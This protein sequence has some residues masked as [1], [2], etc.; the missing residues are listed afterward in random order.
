MFKKDDKVYSLLH[1]EGTII[2]TGKYF[3][4]VMF[5]ND[6]AES[7]IYSSKGYFESFDGAPILFHGK[8]EIIAPPEPQR[9]PDVAVDQPVLVKYNLQDNWNKRHFKGWYNGQISCWANGKTSW[10]TTN[11]HNTGCWPYWT[12][13]LT[14]EIK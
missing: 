1:G 11:L 10:T 2:A 5:K 4:T 3:I 9:F 13:D 12:L 7:F 6:L 14:E 8:P